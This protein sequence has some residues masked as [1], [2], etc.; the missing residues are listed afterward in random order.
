MAALTPAITHGAD[1]SGLV[2]QLDYPSGLTK[3]IKTSTVALWVDH[4]HTPRAH[5]RSHDQVGTHLGRWHSWAVAGVLAG[6]IGVR[7]HRGG[8]GARAARQRGVG[9]RLPRRPA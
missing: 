1:H 2:N 6:H 8:A 9:G 3:W 5:R 7:G 4:D